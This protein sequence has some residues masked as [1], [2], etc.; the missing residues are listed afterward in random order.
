MWEGGTYPH[1]LLLQTGE[2]PSQESKA[3]IQHTPCT[4]DGQQAPGDG[5]SSDEDFQLYKLDKCSPDPIIVPLH[6]NGKK[7]DLELDTGAALSVISVMTRL[8]VF[9]EATP[10]SIKADSLDLQ[11]QAHGNHRYT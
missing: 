10:K 8:V 3:Q 11:G 6:L 7:L 2:K 5:S 1:C 9:S 4:Q